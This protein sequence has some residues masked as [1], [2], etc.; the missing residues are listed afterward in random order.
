MGNQ[1]QTGDPR[2][3]F[4]IYARSILEALPDAVLLLNKDLKVLLANSLFLSSFELREED[5]G[6]CSLSD[7]AG[8]EFN[9]PELFR[10][11]EEI[12]NAG[13]L[14]GKAPSEYIL[15]K[16]KK[17]V[18]LKVSLV[19]DDEDT[20][21]AVCREKGPF[22]LIL[23][24]G[25][26]SRTPEED[27]F[28]VKARFFKLVLDSL[29]IGIAVNNIQPAV[30]FKYMN[31]NFW[32][33]YHVSRESLKGPGSFWDSVYRDPEFREKIK[34]RVIDDVAKGDPEKM[35][36]VDV[37][38]TL[39]DG[40]VFY[41]TAQNIPVPGEDIMVS[42]VM[43]VTRRVESEKKTEQAL[44]SLRIERDRLLAIVSGIDEEV[45]FA[46]TNKNSFWQILP[47]DTDLLWE[48]KLR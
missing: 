9:I 7:I 38:V 45:W 20:V 25:G 8:G 27:M 3:K 29:P 28:S 46:D 17:R 22:I 10:Q 4:P 23:A 40:E 13:K 18:Y 2:D 41:V 5:V 32:K 21:D 37:P 33:F 24:N 35:R 36:W 39:E 44:D 16:T 11:I 15:N 30:K 47:P 12:I 19:P 1:K 43:D 6:E 48:R 34:K 31:D 26:I 14:P 42:T